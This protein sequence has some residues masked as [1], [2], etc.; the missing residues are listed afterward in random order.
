MHS[1]GHSHAC[2]NAHTTH[3]THTKDTHIH[4]RTYTTHTR[5]HTQQ[6]H[7]HTPATPRPRLSYDRVSQR[8]LQALSLSLSLSLSFALSLSL[9]LARSL[10]L[11]ALHHDRLRERAGACGSVCGRVR[12]CGSVRACERVW[13]CAS[14][15]ER[16][17][18]C[19]VGAAHSHVAAGAW[20]ARGRSACR[21]ILNVFCE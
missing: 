18:T 15:W 9:S 20:H 7:A 21:L 8:S 11:Y 5:T 19:G 4:T 16:V 1:C 14:G 12:A 17:G 2:F 10:S 13:E 3:T 6:T